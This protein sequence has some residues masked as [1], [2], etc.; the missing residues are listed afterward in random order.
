MSLNSDANTERL[1]ICMQVYSEVA[2]YKM[3]VGKCYVRW[4][5]GTQPATRRTGP[6]TNEELQSLNLKFECAGCGRN[7]NGAVPRD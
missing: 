2:G 4:G 7:A 3:S 5:V 1:R 6:I